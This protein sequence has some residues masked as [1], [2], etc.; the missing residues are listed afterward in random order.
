VLLV[1]GDK[2]RSR[3]VQVALDL[4]ISGCR[5]AQTPT[6]HLLALAVFDHGTHTAVPSSTHTDASIHSPVTIFE[7]RATPLRE[8]S[9]MHAQI[10]AVCG[11]AEADAT[12]ISIGSGRKNNEYT[13]D[14]DWRCAD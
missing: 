6:M 2:G 9:N 1:E 5:S 13:Q 11:L 4:H 3:W 10:R 8:V 7:G 12:Y 14:E